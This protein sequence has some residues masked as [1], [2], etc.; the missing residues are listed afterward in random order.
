MRKIILFALVLSMPFFASAQ[1]NMKTKQ[2]PENHK[3]MK[4]MGEKHNKKDPKCCKEYGD[5]KSDTLKHKSM[6]CDTMK[7]KKEHKPMG[8][9]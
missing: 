5:K 4:K 8:K 1:S 6:C 7:M 2:M 9:K 3:E